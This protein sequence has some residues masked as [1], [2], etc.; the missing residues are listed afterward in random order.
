MTDR[1]PEHMY[2]IAISDHVFEDLVLTDDTPCKDFWY[3]Y[4]SNNGQKLTVAT[5]LV[6][7]V[8]VTPMPEFGPDAPDRPGAGL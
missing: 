8:W 2:T 3:F 6:Q 7:Y 5:N 4:N 1:K